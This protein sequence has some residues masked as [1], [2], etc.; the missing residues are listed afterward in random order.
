LVLRGIAMKKLLV[1]G[2]LLVLLFGITS[3][4]MAQQPVV[5]A[6]I[7][8][9]PTCGHCHYVL[10]EIIPPLS[11]QYGD[12]LMIVAVDVTTEEGNALFRDAINN[13]DIPEEM[14]GSVPTLIVGETALIGSQDIPNLFPGIIE[15]GLANGGIDWPPIPLLLQALEA[16]GMLDGI[17]DETPS[18]EESATVEGNDDTPTTGDGEP[19]TEDIQ[20]AAEV[21]KPSM[22]ELFN[23][24][25]VGNSISVLVL[26]VLIAS[27]VE[28]GR[29]YFKGAAGVK[30]WP[31]WVIPVLLVIGVV[32]AGYMTFVEVTQTEAVCGPVGDCDTV[33][34]S[35]Y[36]WLFGVIP[37][38]GFGL[39]G[40]VLIALSWLLWVA[41]K[42]E[43]RRYAALALLA[44]SAFG[45]LFSIYLT[46]LEPFV[47]GA[48]CAWC[49]TS[50]L[51]MVLL[52]WASLPIALTA[53]S[54]NGGETE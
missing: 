7:F 34:Q 1:I 44:F 41:G 49:L 23:R 12:Q 5:Y 52:L 8:Y 2:L 42:G 3:P 40:L 38:G 45:T 26:L 35:E 30:S 14:A 11:E 53:G 46:F 21:E 4:V 32:V 43:T 50:A 47:I 29:R 15:E 22:A 54:E 51:V 10:T 33:Q 39:F 25:V 31:T 17:P 36:A 27:A 9:S 19:L 6:V 20:Q 13:I 16:Q 28:V 24:D 37:V 18:A 48:T